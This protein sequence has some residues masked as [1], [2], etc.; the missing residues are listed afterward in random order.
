M[1]SP[2]N[3]LMALDM[4]WNKATLKQGYQ[5]FLLVHVAYWGSG[6]NLFWNFR[7]LS[8]PIPFPLLS[9]PSSPLQNLGGYDP[10][11]PRI[12]AYVLGNISFSSVIESATVNSKLCCHIF[13][14]F[15]V[16]EQREHIKKKKNQIKNIKKSTVSNE[17][18]NNPLPNPPD[19]LSGHELS[20]H[21]VVK[22][23]VDYSVIT[24]EQA[25]HSASLSM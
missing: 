13:C 12:D 2:C 11:P 22:A 8:N 21:D 1:Y 7:V 17:N 3:I 14:I 6:A 15:S 5:I 23:V 20:S 18:N 24:I 9:S 10:Q 19:W 25:E 16:E 4:T